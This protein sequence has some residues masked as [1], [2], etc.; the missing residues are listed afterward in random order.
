M[1]VDMTLEEQLAAHSDW[2]RGPV[3]LSDAGTK[4]CLLQRLRRVFQNQDI[5]T[6]PHGEG[7]AVWFSDSQVSQAPTE[8]EAL[9]KAIVDDTN[10]PP[11]EKVA[12]AFG[13]VPKVPRF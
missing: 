4:G 9:A 3:D 2:R 13:R 10:R 12:G 11:K 1:V 7:W 6:R 8:G 5:Y